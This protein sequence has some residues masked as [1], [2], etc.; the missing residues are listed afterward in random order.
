MLYLQKLQG[1]DCRWGARLSMTTSGSTFSEDEYRTRTYGELSMEFQKLYPQAVR[2]Y[3]L[4]PEMYN[5]LTFV[6]RLSHKEAILKMANDHKHLSRFSD[7]NVRRYLSSHNPNIPR[8]VRTP[9]PKNLSL[10]HIS[11]PT[12]H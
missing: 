1:T 4:I 12:R 6:D 8:Q 2:A 7:R 10:I 3:Q 9:R 11:E 5:C